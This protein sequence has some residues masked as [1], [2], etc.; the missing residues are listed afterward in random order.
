MAT[1]GG[2]AKGLEE[3][4]KH[5]EL[6]YIVPPYKEISPDFFD[7]VSKQ[8]EADETLLFSSELAKIIENIAEE[9]SNQQVIVRSN[10]LKEDSRHSFAGRYDSI[11]VEH[12]TFETLSGAIVKV[13]RSF[14]SELAQDY[15]KEHNIKDDMMG[16]IVQK[17]MPCDWAG[18]MYT[19][20]PSYPDNLSIEFSEDPEAVVNGEGLPLIVEYDKKTMKE[21]FVSEIYHT[22]PENF[23]DHDLL[24]RI[25]VELERL[26]GPSDIEFLVRNDELYLVQRRDITDLETPIPVTIPHYEPEQF[27]G[28]TKVIRGR[29]KY[30]L[31]VFLTNFATLF[32]D[33]MVMLALVDPQRHEQEFTNY[34]EHLIAIDR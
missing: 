1:K 22:A 7:Y 5:S 11:K 34:F 30:T 31:P 2:K 9:F 23:F 17:F 33:E 10:S 26:L 6:G 8:M 14:Y 25:G 15:R 18:V 24:A 12:A 13:Y 4:L 28:K 32:R 21:A 19:S 3:L 29:G 27:L 20:N 16:I